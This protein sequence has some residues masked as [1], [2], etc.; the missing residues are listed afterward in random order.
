MGRAL[1]PVHFNRVRRG[2]HEKTESEWQQQA[3]HKYFEWWMRSIENRKV[4]KEDEE[5]VE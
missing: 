4:D 1:V 2:A 3:D 5:F